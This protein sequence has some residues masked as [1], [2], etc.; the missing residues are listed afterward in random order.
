MG[1]VKKKTAKA[2]RR[3]SFKQRMMKK[4]MIQFL[5][6]TK[7]FV[8]ASGMKKISVKVRPG[9]AVI[10]GR[11]K[12]KT[13]KKVAKA[14]ALRKAA[15]RAVSSAKGAAAKAAAASLLKKASKTVAKA[16]LARAIKK[17]DGV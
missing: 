15:M 6:K 13:A 8:K 12:R 10:Q 17:I 5:P 7:T 9:S 16:K 1:K 14:K 11:K 4:A 3:R 2:K